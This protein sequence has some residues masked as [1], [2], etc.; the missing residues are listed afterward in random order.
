[1]REI[2]EIGGRGRVETCM[3]SGI[4]AR[5]AHGPSNIGG[6]IAARRRPR[7]RAQGPSSIGFSTVM[8]TPSN[9]L[10]DGIVANMHNPWINGGAFWD[11]AAQAADHGATVAG[12]PLAADVVPLAT[13]PVGDLTHLTQVGAT[14]VGGLGPAVGNIGDVVG[15][16]AHDLVAMQAP[17]VGVITDTSSR[18]ADAANAAVGAPSGDPG[19]HASFDAAPSADLAHFA[20]QMLL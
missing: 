20:H 17:P 16:P 1:M 8:D 3:R 12:S 13:L 4:A 5:R 6:G 9:G 11:Q 19:T 2:G 14:A 10:A 18:I 15:G 7:H